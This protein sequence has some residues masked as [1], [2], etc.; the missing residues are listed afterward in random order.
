LIAQR[1]SRRHFL[2]VVAGGVVGALSGGAFINRAHETQRSAPSALLPD[3][4][5]AAPASLTTASGIRL[6]AI[7]T[8]FVAVKRA[9]RQL[10]GLESARLLSIA[11]D[12][13]WTEWMP[14][15]TWVIEH[16][17]GLI[18]VDTG[19][20][21]QINT[22]GYLDCDPITAWVYQNNLRFAVTPSDELAAQM[23]GLNLDLA[24][25]RVVVQTHL[26]SDHM[27][28]LG[29]FPDAE[30]YVPAADYPSGV[31]VLSC[32]FPAG[33]APRF[34]EFRAQ[35]LP[36]FT[37]AHALTRQGDVWIVPTPGHS[38]G[39]QSVIFDDGERAYFLAGDASFDEA[40]LLEDTV[41]GIVADVGQA[42]ASLAAIRT[43]A[44]DRP[45][46]YLPTHDPESRARLMSQQVTVM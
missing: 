40:Q 3:I 5:Q 25:V 37:T 8:G 26:H 46:V 4:V 30:V 10:T 17:E 36:G 27:G 21:S 29:A 15:N 1:P 45:T 9:H 7:Q 28:G 18:V 34:A 6:H 31:G 23:R 42:R 16:P 38:M 41:G 12:T 14:I 2:S 43:F 13:R 39:H 22:P 11:A 19:E 32:H 24:D 44:A 33:F 35:T 20:T